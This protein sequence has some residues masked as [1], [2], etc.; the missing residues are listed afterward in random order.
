MIGRQHVIATSERAP[1]GRPAP[2]PAVPRRASAARTR[3]IITTC[4]KKSNASKVVATA[5]LIECKDESTADFVAGQKLNTG[6]CVRV[7]E[8]RLVVR[9]EHEEKFRALVRTL[10]LGMPG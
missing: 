9:L 5:L 7:A 2:V 4:A 3:G 10:G 8:R 6:L 1:V